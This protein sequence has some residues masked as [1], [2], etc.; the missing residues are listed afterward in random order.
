MWESEGACTKRN[1]LIQAK[2]LQIDLIFSM[3][4][5]GCRANPLIQLMADADSA[6]P[7]SFAHVGIRY[8]SREANAAEHRRG[9]HIYGVVEWRTKVLQ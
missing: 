5:Q 8:F 6:R 9:L 2:S 1:G 3:F 4:Y 7:F